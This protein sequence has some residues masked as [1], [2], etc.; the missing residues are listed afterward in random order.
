M[1]PE[2][3]PTEGMEI[4]EWVR[5]ARTKFPGKY[6]RFVFHCVVPIAGT[7]KITPQLEKWNEDS[8]IN[9]MI[10]ISDEAFARTLLVNYWEQYATKDKT[11]SP[12][13]TERKLSNKPASQRMQGGWSLDGL[14]LFNEL[15]QLVSEER[16]TEQIKIEEASADG[17]D[18]PENLTAKFG[19][20]LWE[21]SEHRYG[22]D[23]TR[24]TF[25]SKRGKRRRLDD[26]DLD[27][28]RESVHFKTFVE[29]V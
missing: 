15:C 8:D 18:P 24:K 1:F 4:E 28:P 6:A 7:E 23:P 17:L 2:E 5:C 19:E 27:T 26:D 21:I 14:K 10:S 20:Y 22:Y 3:D 13:F 29:G 16:T 11:V 9:T 12:L 25:V